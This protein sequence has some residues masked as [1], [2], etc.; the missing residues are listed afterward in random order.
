MCRRFLAVV[1]ALLWAT[2]AFSAPATIVSRGPAIQFGAEQL[3][4]RSPSLDREFLVEVMPPHSPRLYPTQTFPVVYALDNGYRIAGLV[5][6]NMGASGV[7]ANAYVVSVGYK[8]ADYGRRMHDLMHRPVR[9]NNRDAGG[10]AEAFERFLIDELR[11]LIEAGHPVDHKRAIFI[12]QSASGLFGANLIERRP[13]AFS[14]FVL[15]SPSFWL[16]PEALPRVARAKGAGERVFIA[17]GGKEEA[18]MTRPAAALAKALRGR[19]RTELKVYPGATHN[20]H[21]LRT[22]VDALPAFLPTQQ[23]LRAPP[24]RV[25]REDELKPFLGLFRLE[26]GRTLR[27]RAMDGFLWADLPGGGSTAFITE[28]PGRFYSVGLDTTVT[29]EGERLTLRPPGAEFRAVRSE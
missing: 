6:R 4:V 18:E 24:Y 2:A 25:L 27:F 20:A 1:A 22:L 10:G 26:D 3:I 17:V 28:R 8:P 5:L 16:E 29:F 7:M 12:G 13:G 11:P 14:A 9:F 23:D 21:Y 19:F 15:G